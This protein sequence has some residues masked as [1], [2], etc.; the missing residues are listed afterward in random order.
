MQTEQKGINQ[1]TIN[2]MELY[3]RI[4]LQNG[5]SEPICQKERSLEEKNKAAATL[6][7]AKDELVKREKYTGEDPFVF[8]WRKNSNAT[9]EAEFA[10]LHNT[11]GAEE[12][13]KL[14]VSD[15]EWASNKKFIN[16]LNQ[17]DTITVPYK[18]EKPGTYSVELTYRSGSST[19]SL[20][21]EDSAGNIK[22]GFV[23]AGN[24]DSKVTKTV[25]FDMV[26]EKAGE[27]V[28]TLKGHTKDAPQLDK[29][30]I[31]PKDVKLAEFTVNASVEGEGGTITPSG[32]TKVT[33]GENVEFKITP[34]KTHKVADVLVNGESVGAVT[35]YTLKDVKANA[36]IVAK[37]APASYT[38][39]NR[40]N[41]PT[42]VNGTTITAEAEHFELKNTGENEKWPLQVSPADWASNGY[43]VNAMNSGDQIILPYPYPVLYR[44][45]IF[46][47][48]Y[49]TAHSYLYIQT[50]L[51]H[52]LYIYYPKYRIHHDV[53]LLRSAF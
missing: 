6:Q 18:V 47:P 51:H 1:E 2:R 46:Q 10:E 16:C 41:F 42:E 44:L 3:R 34:D 24:D 23:V 7:T 17:G 35:S 53:L 20:A 15:G 14:S 30:E 43:F 29:F 21:W 36:T 52:T 25:T 22:S 45:Q 39:E 49:L 33:E 38:E 48:E 31:T 12:Q 11:G 8:P 26:A 40:F 4:L 13:W 50:L 5:F 32:E 28:L 9:L 37:F 19:N 27:G